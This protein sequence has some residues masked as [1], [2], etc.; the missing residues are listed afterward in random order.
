M[1]IS[2]MTAKTLKEKEVN[3]LKSLMG[4]V[5]HDLKTPLHSIE[6]DLDMVRIFI[7]KIPKCDIDIACQEFKMNRMI[8]NFDVEGILNSL[9]ATCQFMGMSINRSQDF[10]KSS[11]N[12]ALVPMMETFEL[13]LALD[14]SVTCLNHLDSGKSITLHPLS[15]GI[16][17]QIISDQHW[18]SENALCLLSNAVKY[19][20]DGC[21]DVRVELIDAPVPDVIYPQISTSRDSI[22]DECKVPNPTARL[23]IR[24]ASITSTS[25]RPIPLMATGLLR[26][27]PNLVTWKKDRG[28]ELIIRPGSG[29]RQMVMITV[30][31]NGI[32]IPVNKRS[33]LFQPFAQAQ[34]MAGGTG[35]GLYSLAKRMEAL[36]GECGV[37]GRADGKQGSVFWFSF[38]YRPDE[39]RRNLVAE[40]ELMLSVTADMIQPMNI[41]VIDDSQSILKVT[42]RMLKMNGHTIAT[43]TNGSLGLKMMKGA[44]AA[45]EYDIVLTDIQ[46]PV[47]DG[48]EAT[49]RYREYEDNEIRAE[50]IGNVISPGCS[51]RARNGTERSSLTT[52]ITVGNDSNTDVLHLRSSF[53]NRIRNG[54]S[55]S[56]T[57]DGNNSCNSY[58]RNDD[59]VSN[60][61]K[62]FRN[63]LII[64][65]MSAN[66][67]S[68]TEQ[69]AL[70]C[71]MDYFLS[72]PFAYN[73]LLPIIQRIQ[74]N[75]K[76]L[77]LVDNKEN[78]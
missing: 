29:M 62:N 25:E 36:G 23:T 32:G 31:D 2:S 1:E 35:L 14:L 5:A 57:V 68:L 8:G 21:I 27:S 61:K 10:M 33:Q 75:R 9:K 47:M 76:T 3:Q 73:D 38:P 65:G 54:V 43:A 64:I 49:R 74:K 30:E 71:G 37:S 45:Q 48:I 60:N 70:D 42:V 20:D 66:S 39:S 18:I 56:K 34:R 78:N 51:K 41:L 16:C 59:I 22:R 72:K 17:P 28:T 6:A 4:N 77:H 69:E 52:T 40:E 15:D 50:E 53:L 63:R 55:I 12:I 44:Y 19:S 26:S 11:N 67:D 24:S 7:S 13:K 58:N 46:M